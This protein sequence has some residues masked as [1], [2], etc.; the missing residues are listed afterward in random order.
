MRDHAA[1]VDRAA[2]GSGSGDQ[3]WPNLFS[4][5]G[6]SAEGR[7]EDWLDANQLLIF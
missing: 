1:A 7:I 5:L 2:D 6:I 3:V 4:D